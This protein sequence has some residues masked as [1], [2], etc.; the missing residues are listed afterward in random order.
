ML[1]A[2]EEGLAGISRVEDSVSMPDEDPTGDIADLILVSTE[3][4]VS[5]RGASPPSP[6]GSTAPR[7]GR[8]EAGTP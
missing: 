8:R 1:F 3:R 7:P 4:I 2:E 5:E 6:G